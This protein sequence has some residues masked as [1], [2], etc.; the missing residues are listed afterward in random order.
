[1]A[2]KAPHIVVRKAT[3]ADIA[4]LSEFISRFVATGDLLPRTLTELHDLLPNFFIADDNGKI[5]GCATLEIYSRKLAEI[6]SLAV[7]PE[8]Q[9]HGVGKQLV[10]ACV[11]L[12]KQHNVYEVM[13]I[14]S[15][16]EFFKKCGFDFTLPNLRKAFFLTT[17]DEL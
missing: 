11:D 1:M 14:S 7:A 15:A 13:A 4:P 6:R 5:V 17:R 8:A 3:T 12:A 2:T 16:E 9:G 10:E